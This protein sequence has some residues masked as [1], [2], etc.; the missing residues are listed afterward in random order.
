MANKQEA[1]QHPTGVRILNK[2]SDIRRR[3]TGLGILLGVA[4]GAGLGVAL[5]NLAF[6]IGPGI[7]FGVA[8]GMI[9]GNKHAKLVQE[10][11]D[12][13]HGHDA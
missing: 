6:G 5:G 9:L 2:Q 13:E 4:I 3:Y 11:A 12:K 10:K 1:Q 7:A 8:F